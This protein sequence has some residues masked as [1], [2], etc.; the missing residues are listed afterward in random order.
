MTWETSEIG[1]L[2]DELIGLEVR[3]EV[4]GERLLCHAPAGRIPPDVA[5]RIR[6]HQ[7]KLLASL[8]QAA[9]ADGLPALVCE[10]NLP[11]EDFPLASAQTWMWLHEELAGSNDFYAMS[12][13]LRI[14]GRFDVGA[15]ASAW[16][17]L[18]E[19][20]AALRTVCAPRSGEAPLQ[21]IRAKGEALRLCGALAPGEGDIERAR[22]G[23]LLLARRNPIRAGTGGAL[24]TA[25]LYAQSPE[26]HYMQIDVHH[27]VADGWSVS[28]ML[29]DLL[30]IYRSI[31]TGGM[32]CLPRLEASH[33]DFV[34]WQAVYLHS[35][36]FSTDIAFWKAALES[37]PQ[38]FEPWRDHRGGTA[39]NGEASIVLEPSL[40]R[41]AGDWATANGGTLHSTLLAVWCAT[42]QC[43][44]QQ[45]E[46]VIGTVLAGR[47]YPA[48]ESTVGCFINTLPIRVHVDPGAT[49]SKLHAQL[50]D[51]LLQCYEHQHCPINRIAQAVNPARGTASNPLFNI[52]FLLQNHPTLAPVRDGLR[53]DEVRLP[54]PVGGLDLRLV[55]GQIN[56][57]FTLSLEYRGQMLDGAGADRLLRIASQVLAG[58]VQ[59]SHE[60]LSSLRDVL[61][62]G[63]L[64]RRRRA[65]V[66]ATFTIEPLLRS[67]EYWRDELN[68][69]YAL[70]IVGYAQVL[71]ALLDPAGAMRCGSDHNSLFIRLEDWVVEAS[72]LPAKADEFVEACTDYARHC[73]TPLTVWMCPATSPPG[74]PQ[75]AVVEKMASELARRL[76]VV[77]GVELRPYA[78]YAGRYD[79]S[80]AADAYL[81]HVAHVPYRPHVYTALGTL[82]ARE[83]AALQRPAL[84]AVVVD[85]DNTLWRGVCGEAET[86]AVVIDA[87]ARSVQLLLRDLRSRGVLLC[88]CSKNAEHDVRAALGASGNILSWLDFSERRVNWHR[89]SDNIRA[90]AEDLRIGLDSIVF[91]D[92]NPAEC[93]EVEAACP[94][95]RC[96]ALP[97][98]R[99]EIPAFLQGIWDFDVVGSSPQAHLRLETYRTNEAREQLREQCANPGAYLRE[100]RLEV[101]MRQLAAPDHSRVAEL[102][103]RTTQFNFSGRRKSA[104]ELATF[105]AAAGA[106]CRVVEVRDRFGDYGLTGVL[107]GRIME[108][109]CELDTFL[110]SCR[111]LGKR[112]EHVA[113]DYYIAALASMGVRSVSLEFIRTERN[114]PARMF[115]DDYF[116]QAAPRN[117]TAHAYETS[118]REQ[119]P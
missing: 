77:S 34:R 5:L 50:R 63:A 10:A 64:P 44:A 17:A 8:R 3:L 55:A 116:S 15:L 118:I 89:K 88:L 81:D 104:G 95:V 62:W 71:E 110:L 91:V 26:D 14:V 46:F 30:E 78:S 108:D 87:A 99:D 103:G 112:V 20:H 98:N 24:A 100:L 115:A 56:H 86:G 4:A 79:F 47:P 27:L 21:R 23:E 58:A 117:A 48:F 18:C 6:K 106:V 1:Q 36:A 94:Q 43:W 7:P 60:P 33:A 28:L 57:E 54:H 22:A 40:V 39:G 101:T 49:F 109:H 11:V 13:A 9:R 12:V 84:K 97:S 76:V 42:L 61:S 96:V 80:Q 32:P 51:D 37:A 93:A 52:A 70:Q 59:T 31:E 2:L 19:R 41:K 102:T 69:P 92:D 107:L 38:S 25:T 72:Q 16:E 68:L 119:K 90:M 74:S 67:F 114:L 83:L 75:A 66:G 82:L 113:M 45:D 29:Q 65:V 105:A 53:V 85:A 73:P 35:A 111:V